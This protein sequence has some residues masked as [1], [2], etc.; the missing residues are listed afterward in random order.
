[1]DIHNYDQVTT[2]FL[3]TVVADL[4]PLD[5][6]PLIPAYATDVTVITP[7]AGNVAIFNGTTWSEIED[8]RGTVVYDTTTQEQS[9]IE[10]LGVI[11]VDKTELVPTEYTTWNG[12]AW[13]VDL[14]AAKAANIL[15]IDSL[16]ETQ[17]LTFITGGSGQSLTYQEKADDA[18]AY[19]DASYPVDLTGYPF[20]QAEVNATGNTSTVATDDILAA[21]GAWIVK[22]AAIEEL[23]I[24]A[25]IDVNASIDISAINVVLD[26]YKIAIEAI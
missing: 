2:E 10:D 8:N 3:S 13:I 16:A 23:R 12:S 9:T 26:A 20:V 25:K 1:M 18:Q 21:R 7:S 5:S 15:T 24:K 19:K 4:D 14:V 22:G 17:R 11:P 6:L